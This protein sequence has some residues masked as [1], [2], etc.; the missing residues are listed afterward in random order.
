MPRTDNDS[1]DGRGP[2]QLAVAR[3][4][5]RSLL[6]QASQLAQAA[7]QGSDR[8]G[9]APAKRTELQFVANRLS[10]SVARPLRAALA[11]VGDD[12][13]EDG[14]QTAPDVAPWGDAAGDGTKL[15]ELLWQLAKGATRLCLQPGLPGELQ[16]ATAALQDL[17]VRHAPGEGPD[18]MPARVAE[19]RQI[20]AGLPRRIRLV[21]NG[22]YLA[23]NVD[24]VT[25][26]LGERI[27]TLPQMAL[28]RCGA[29]ALKPFC[30][31]SHVGIQAG[32]RELPGR[33]DATRDH[34][35]PALGL[36]HFRR[37][38]RVEDRGSPT[39]GGGDEGGG[40]AGGATRDRRAGA[41][42]ETHQASLSPG[43]PAVDEVRL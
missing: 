23:T 32:G 3:R 9:P 17:G 5:M 22:P 38:P 25:N 11:G 35:G 1:A 40:T 30:D 20:T 16:E 26:W 12:G 41:L 33:L 18:A 19:L 34:A 10:R 7:Q 24:H 37:T 2:N 36:D 8:S 42:R 15:E 39:G 14:A 4:A 6:A 43:G 29:S 28:C 27:E 13:D 21:G 31:G